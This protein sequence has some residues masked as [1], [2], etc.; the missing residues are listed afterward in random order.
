MAV[1][2]PDPGRETGQWDATRATT[3]H[4]LTHCRNAPR[5]RW[6]PHIGAWGD[7]RLG[8]MGDGEGKPDDEAQCDAG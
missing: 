5:D 6:E 3:T 2:A 8:W 4:A 1:Q 7:P